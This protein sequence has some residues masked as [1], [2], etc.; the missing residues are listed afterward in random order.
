VGGAIG[1][2]F[3]ISVALLWVPV[4]PGVLLA[5]LLG[6]SGFACGRSRERDRHATRVVQVRYDALLAAKSAVETQFVERTAELHETSKRLQASLDQV[7]GLSAARTDFFNNVSHELRS[8][9]TLIVAPLEDLVAGRPP[10]GGERAAFEAMHRSAMRLLRLINQLLDL[11]KIDAGE[12]QI[13]PMPTELCELLLATTANFEVAAQKRGIVIERRLPGASAPIVI[14]SAWIESAVTNLIANA[15]RLTGRG[16][17]VRVELEDREHEVAIAIADDGPGISPADREKVFERFGQGDSRGRM[18]G[19]TG[20][21][22]A[23]VREAVRLHGGTVEL[24]S[25]LG[26]GATFTLTL[27][28]GYLVPASEP[29]TPSHEPIALLP[30]DPGETRGGQ[31]PGPDP[32]APLVLV[33]EDNADL[34]DFIADVLA[35]RCRVQTAVDARQALYLAQKLRPDAIVSDVAMP[36]MDGYELCRAVRAR[37]EIRTTPVLLVTARTEAASII[38]GFEAGANDY[39]VKPFYGRELLARVEVHVRLRRMVQELALR[40]RHALL[41]VMAASVAHQVRNPLTTMIAGL[42]AMRQR[43]G[44]RA[45]PQTA[46]MMDVMLECAGR[47]EQM[48]TD[49]MNLSRVDRSAA[50]R[51]RPSDGL[52]TAVRLARTRVADSIVIEERIERSAETEGWPGDMNHVFLNLLDNAIRALPSGGTIRLRA[53][54]EHDE[55]VIHVEDSGPGMDEEMARR[56]FQPF[57]T[58][59]PPGEGTGLGLAI[60]KDI[61]ERHGGQISVQ[62]SEL[63]GA[64]LAIQ[65][66]Y[67]R[68][69]ISSRPALLAP[70]L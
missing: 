4:L 24:S 34:R 44:D 3:G 8:P 18:A 48:T 28:R 57:F 45:D 58:T 1:L 7:Q 63:G 53:M 27:P 59:R 16:G 36:E 30:E 41:G 70:T 32:N 67:L 29:V 68:T 17:T 49:L 13:T 5:L 22:L 54:T 33:V 64:R 15:I 10:P 55:Y 38:A 39:I 50:C 2:A 42:P 52:Q 14:D 20:I 56:A 25:E 26:H 12:L 23:L 19:G 62:R 60:A 35:V 47:I 61:V 11:A 69:S 37:D 46:E 31:R 51:F 6:I 43:L 21:G 66:P 65:L 40:E 9:L